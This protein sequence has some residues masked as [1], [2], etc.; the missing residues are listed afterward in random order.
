MERLRTIWKSEST[1]NTSLGLIGSENTMRKHAWNTVTHQCETQRMRNDLATISRRPQMQMQTVS[2]KIFPVISESK[3]SSQTQCLGLP[4]EH[5]G[6]NG[7]QYPDRLN[8]LRNLINDTEAKRIST[9][10]NWHQLEREPESSG[11]QLRWPRTWSPANLCAG[12]SPFTANVPTLFQRTPSQMILP[13]FM[14]IETTLG[15]IE[16]PSSKTH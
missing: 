8:W 11:R 10:D 14:A 9:A 16:L 12:R 1:N 5:W 7:A 2:K 3:A 15:C 13:K 4:T 6:L